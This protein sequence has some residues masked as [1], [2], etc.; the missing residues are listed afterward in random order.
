M[1]KVKVELDKSGK[2][3]LKEQ[4]E[5][6]QEY[7]AGPS[8]DEYMVIEP[9][10]VVFVVY[11]K[12][13]WVIFEIQVGFY[14]VNGMN[15]IIIAETESDATAAVREA[16]VNAVAKWINLTKHMNMSAVAVK[17]AQRMVKG[18]LGAVK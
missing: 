15:S 3:L 14:Y 1:F 16:A 10:K 18:V 8:D 9:R 7:K 12:I 5:E 17:K 6:L 13:Y 11:I 4:L 2:S